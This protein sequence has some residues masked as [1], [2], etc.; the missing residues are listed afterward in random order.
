MERLRSARFECNALRLHHSRFRGG[1]NAVYLR[2][3]RLMNVT[4]LHEEQ[5]D[6][7]LS[8]VALK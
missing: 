7:Q 3:L 2:S 8:I 1:A 4:N 6:L 5:V